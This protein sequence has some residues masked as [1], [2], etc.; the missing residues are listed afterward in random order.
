MKKSTR[1]AKSAAPKKKRGLLFDAADLPRI[2]AN[3][4]DPRFTEFWKT[5]LDADMAAD[6]NFLK[7]ELSLTNHTAHL[8]RAQRILDRTSLIYLIN[9]DPAQLALAKLAIR[10]MLD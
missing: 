3:T 8:L 1:S 5:Q 9:R 2:R 7:N 6:A 10:R 4:K